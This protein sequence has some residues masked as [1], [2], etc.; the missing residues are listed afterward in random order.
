[1][2]FGAIDP[3]SVIGPPRL[4]GLGSVA[5]DDRMVA[6]DEDPMSAQLV[7]RLGATVEPGRNYLPGGGQAS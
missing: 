1:V 2:V 6:L 3:A 7:G 4:A 5:H